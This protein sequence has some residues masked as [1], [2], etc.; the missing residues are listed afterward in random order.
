MK[1]TVQYT[2]LA[3]T[4]LLAPLALAGVTVSV[5]HFFSGEVAGPVYEGQGVN[6]LVLGTNGNLYVTATAGGEGA[7]WNGG[8]GTI[9]RMGSDGSF[10]VMHSFSGS[11][12]KSPGGPGRPDIYGNGPVLVQGLDGNFYGA[13]YAGGINFDPSF[14][15]YIESPTGRGTI[16]RVAP[17]GNLTTLVSFNGTNGSRPNS[18]ILAQDGNFYGTTLGD[19]GENTFGTA[20]RMTPDG[21]LTTLFSFNGTNGGNPSSLV[22]GK[23]G[24]F[25]G[26]A[27][28]WRDDSPYPYGGVFKMTP[29]GQVSRFASFTDTN[30]WGP[31]SLMQ[32]SDGNFYG[33]TYYGGVRT[34]NV[35]NGAIVYWGTIFKLT[36]GGK[37][38]TLVAFTGSNG[39][40]PI[41]P[42][43]EGTDGNFYGATAQGG[44]HTQAV[45]EGFG[46]LFRMT[47]EGKLTTLFFFNGTQGTQPWSALMQ[48]GDGSFYGTTGYYGGAQGLDF[49]PGEIFQMRVTG[50]ESPK[51]ISTSQ[52][53]DNFTL[54]WLAL[55]GRSYQLQF[56]TNLTQPNWKNV[57]GPLTATNTVASASDVISANPQRFY[58]IALLP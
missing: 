7:G 46:T 37:L 33:T 24:N 29:S 23:D 58:R 42:L 35:N 14:N 8:C 32:A 28:I 26:T 45:P 49:G 21:T 39:A 6:G 22:Q 44:I 31:F 1:T 47:P 9:S 3:A 10:T 12:G 19:D 13:T 11:D 18:L 48:A 15:C 53:G 34:V 20:F 27:H 17:D 43:I 50:A 55:V 41:A 30:A 16:F 52:S 54:T 51:I 2:I 5:R 36:S 40:W 38:T 56:N 25:Y 4:L 57:G